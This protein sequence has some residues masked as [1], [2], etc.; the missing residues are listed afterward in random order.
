M[1]FAIHSLCAQENLATL[2]EVI[3]SFGTVRDCLDGCAASIQKSTKSQKL[4]LNEL[5]EI[6]SIYFAYLNC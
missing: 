4:L 3:V 6:V 1:R 2:K 5:I